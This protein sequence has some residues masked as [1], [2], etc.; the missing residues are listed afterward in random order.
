MEEPLTQLCFE[1]RQQSTLTQLP[2][3]RANWM[4]ERSKER[5][6]ERNSFWKKEIVFERKKERK[7]E[8][9]IYGKEIVKDWMNEW[10]K[11][12]KK[13]RNIEY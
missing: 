12:R 6:K 8:R 9:N 13:E 1:E 2:I 11:I 3:M 4:I 10:K 5:G 7:K